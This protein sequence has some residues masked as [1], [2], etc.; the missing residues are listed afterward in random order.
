MKSKRLI[1]AII[2]VVMLIAVMPVSAFA[3][4]TP[5][6]WAKSEMDNANTAGILTA[7][8]AKNFTRSMSRDE[9]CEMVVLMAEKALDAPLPLPTRNPFTDCNSE[10]VQKAFQ[11]GIVNGR[12]PTTFDPDASVARQEIAA[13]MYRALTGIETKLGK[14]LLSPPVTA[15]TFKD[16]S[17]IHD[18]A[19]LPVRYAVA[20]GI[21]KG[22]D[23]NNFNPLN[24]ISSEECVAVVIRSNDSTH[25]KLD[26][27]L[28]TTQLL[29]K[30]MKHLNIGYA[31]GDSQA[32]VS[33]NVILPTR[34][35]GNAV[36]TW[37]SSNP[38]VIAADGRI[39]SAGGSSATLTATATLGG[40]S[41]TASFTLT[42]TSLSGDQLLVQNAKTELELSFFNEKDTLASVT[43]RVFLPKTI[44]GLDVSWYS[45]RPSVVALNGEVTVPTDNSVITVNLTASFGTG[46]T[47]ATKV[48]VL[49]VRNSSFVSDS[50]TL[51]NIKL[52]MSLADVT[53]VLSTEKSSLTLATGETWYFYHTAGTYNNFIAVALRS[54][55]VIGVYTMVNGW[56]TYLRDATTAKTITVADA[57]KV[58]GIKVDVYTDTYSSNKQYAAFLYDTTSGIT[59]ERVLNVTATETFVTMLVNAY[60]NLFGNGTGQT[61]L[62]NDAVLS[63]SA[64]SHSSDMDSYEY[65]S[66]TGRTGNTTYATRAV[67]AGFPATATVQG[68]AIAYNSQ[69]P[70]DFLNSLI[71]NSADRASILSASAGQIGVGYSGSYT[72]AYKTLLTLVF[73]SSTKIT[74]ITANVTSINVTPGTTSDII[75]TINPTTFSETFTVTS[76]DAT[77]F[78]VTAQATASNTRTYR[79]TGIA[80]GTASLLVRGSDN[81][82][83]L[84][85]PVTVGAV[86][87][88]NLSLSQ[89]SMQM[90]TAST[91]QLTASTTPVS[92]P[93]VTWS[94]SDATIASVNAST[95]LVT[96]YAKTGSVVITATVKS[97]ATANI[98]R[99]VNISVIS[100]TT[101]PAANSTL[102]MAVGTAS[103]TTTLSATVTP[104]ASTTISWTSS[105]AAVADIS[106][107]LLTAK[108]AG[109]TTLTCTIKRDGYTNVTRSFTVVVT[110]SVGWPTSATVPSGTVD[111]EIGETKPIVVT[112]L[113]ATAANKIISHTD[114]SGSEFNVDYSTGNLLITGNTV[115]STPVSFL[116]YAKASD[117]T[118]LAPFTVTVNITLK[119]PVVTIRDVPVSMTAGEAKM[120]AADVTKIAS[121]S[122]TWSVATASGDATATIDPSTGML[123]GITGTGSITVIA[124]VAA[125]AESSEAYAT[126]VIPII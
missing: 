58:S 118:L 68:G 40:T 5:S 103:E 87:A 29:D 83:L 97:S 57:N 62:T 64:R 72:G 89:T 35:A 70:F 108:S 100:V 37:A 96:T 12:T 117:T 2:A 54:N 113:P 112:Y 39:V 27:N 33:Q 69:N 95:G 91:A 107:T 73:A 15:L 61:A 9:F 6:N 20:N 46:S 16:S 28:S 31:Y 17:K 21:F 78:S 42:T 25:A 71:A 105:N 93:V 76:S 19:I 86:Y 124:T 67:A 122:V 92:G 110:G 8:A 11:F 43:G 50:I 26:A 109:T 60:R 38:S 123:N 1:A 56:E 114:Y 45:D 121:P 65:F 24:A 3:S 59:S 66:A 75:L 47:R 90:L 106:G 101:V 125:T 23:L 63:N 32:A 14:V 74:S 36:I 98:T 81:R 120:F 85:I 55:R 115:T 99:T 79:I 77:K 119:R 49:Q 4:R 88:T 94:S 104:S 80:N 22:D 48:F 52:G 116:V 41:R 51:H 34:G 84:T 13:M 102:Q 82:A 126:V 111:I 44:M 53:K 10:Y 30:T 7:N 18:Y